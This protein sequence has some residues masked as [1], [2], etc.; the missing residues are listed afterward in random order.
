MIREVVKGTLLLASTAVVVPYTISLLAN[1]LYGWPRTKRRAFSPR[2]VYNF[3]F[4]FLQNMYMLLRYA[5]LFFQW[6]SFY[7]RADPFRV[8]KVGIL[9]NYSV[10]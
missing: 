2:K 10:Y 3:N 5:P 9:I 7:K 1:V 6:K 4:T 8:R